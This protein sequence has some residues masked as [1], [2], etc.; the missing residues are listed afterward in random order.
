MNRALGCVGLEHPIIAQ[1]LASRAERV[2]STTA[3]A[4]IVRR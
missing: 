2:N 1:R 3:K 4:L